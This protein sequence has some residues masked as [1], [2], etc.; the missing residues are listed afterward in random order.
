MI[1]II[2]IFCFFNSYRAWERHLRG[3]M[4]GDQ[5]SQSDTWCVCEIQGVA[6]NSRHADLT[7]DRRSRE[8]LNPAKV[9][10]ADELPI[11]RG[12][13]PSLHVDQR[14]TAIAVHVWSPSAASVY[15]VLLLAFCCTITDNRSSNSFLLLLRICPWFNVLFLCWGLIC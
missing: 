6:V 9:K 4:C 2:C 11:I 13:L 15:C 8:R 12:L 5:S 10:L 14:T 7:S 3:L 1:C